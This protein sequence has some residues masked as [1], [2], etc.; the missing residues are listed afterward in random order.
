MHAV[1]V[2]VTS[3]KIDKLLPIYTSNMLMKFGVH[4][5][6]PDKVRVWKPYNPIWPPDNHLESEISE[7]Q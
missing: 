1:I 4:I 5:Q 3:L 6:R 2:V 7:N